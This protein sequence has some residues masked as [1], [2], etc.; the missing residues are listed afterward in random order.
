MSQHLYRGQDRA[1]GLRFVDISVPPG[2]TIISA[3]IEFEVDAR[4]D[5]PADLVI[6]GELSASPATFEEIDGNIT[7]RTRT[8]T[9]LPWTPALW[10]NAGSKHSTRN[11]QAIV[12]ELVDQSG[13][14]TY[15]PMAFIIEGTGLREARTWDYAPST[16][17]KLYIRYQAPSAP[18]HTETTPGASSTC[19]RP[20]IAGSP[21]MMFSTNA[22]R[23]GA[24]LLD[25][26]FV[27]VSNTTDLFYIFVD[28]PDTIDEVR[29]TMFGRG[30]KL[31][32][33][34]PFDFLGTKTE[35]DNFDATGV[36]AAFVP[37][38]TD[39]VQAVVRYL[40]GSTEVISSTYTAYVQ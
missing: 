28:G 21:R 1:V 19:V 37:V 32:E 29:F 17:P 31:E 38:G 8:S 27:N 25:G 30:L 14:Q 10:Q 20:P 18:A 2:A 15:N 24:Q 16:A 40:D 12:Q 33:K 11:V 7:D 23:S 35:A 39:T 3:W 4:S 26:A 9:S 22:D 36:Y 6:T 5:Q 34:C 13:W